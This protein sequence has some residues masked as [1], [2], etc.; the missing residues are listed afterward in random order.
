MPMAIENLPKDAEALLKIIISQNAEI[1][2]LQEQLRLF[3]LRQYQ[4]KSER[5]IDPNQPSLFN[6]VEAE[7]SKEPE[8]KSSAADSEIEI[9]SHKRKAR[10][11]RIK[12]SDDLPK[13]R[14]EHD[15][16]A[17]D[18]ICPQHNIEM[19]RIGEEISEQ[20]DVIPA[21][22]QVLQNVR[23][24]YACSCCDESP[25]K[26]S[27]LPPQPIPKSNASPG[28]LAYIATSK[29]EDHL[30]LYRQEKIFSRFGADIDRAT[31]AR[32]MIKI[33]ELCQP[34]LNLMLEDLLS[35]D[36]LHCDETSLQVLKEPG[37]L[38]ENKSYMWVLARGEPAKP[39]VL[40]NYSP[41]RAAYV[42]DGLLADY[43][44]YLN[45]DGY[46]S[47]E[48]FA[49]KRPQVKLVG[50][51]AHARRKFW[52]AEKVGK[53]AGGSNLIATEGLSF[54]GQLYKIERDIKDISPEEK[55]SARQEKSKII[56]EKFRSWLDQKMDEVPGSVLTGQAISYTNSEWEKLNR[57]LE[58]GRL[59]IDNN[60]CE[61]KIRPFCVGRKNWMFSD[62]PKGAHASAAIYSLIETA[63]ANDIDPF[64]YLS[65]IFAE[66]PKATTLADYEKLLAYN[67][68]ENYSVTNLN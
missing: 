4:K 58:D 12:L 34:L 67:A 68:R 44:G 5:F 20:L 41:T 6:E 27:S 42:L 39:L 3:A 37:R 51:M 24:K 63:K 8:S 1:V 36:I 14:I 50:C 61:N 10:G 17:E 49:S 59:H 33:S 54:I 56:L 29:Y 40:Y 25:I 48:S 9:K 66:L 30:P 57:Y 65:L 26:I 46:S 22:I 2:S 15:L 13:V 28:L 32:W 19:E 55:Y 35:G 11:K 16:S 52:E 31:M 53:K 7:A 47:Y 60:F 64:D 23:F 45:T 43:R 21:T 38:A 62:T 18:K